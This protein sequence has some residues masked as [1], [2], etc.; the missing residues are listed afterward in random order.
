MIDSY[1]TIHN[2]QIK[3]KSKPIIQILKK[4]HYTF[5]V[6]ISYKYL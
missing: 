2:D 5:F 4:N 6:L 3:V 1:Y